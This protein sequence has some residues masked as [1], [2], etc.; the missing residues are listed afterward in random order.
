MFKKF[1]GA[2]VVAGSFAAVSAHALDVD[3]ALKDYKKQSGVEGS[4]KSV[5]S[6]TLN[7]LMTLWAEGFNK[8]Y[9]SVKIEIEGKG[10]G[11]APPA[12]ISGTAKG[13]S[14][15]SV[16][17]WCCAALESKSMGRSSR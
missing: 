7:N 1:A 10:S 14:R 4:L 8:E 16:P 17:P 5:G 3:P 13:A 11:T 6:D 2:L 12:M 9:P 15:P